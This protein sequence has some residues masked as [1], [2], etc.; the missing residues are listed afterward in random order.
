MWETVSTC[1]IS[2]ELYINVLPRFL[3]LIPFLLAP[4]SINL[5]NVVIIALLQYRWQCPRKIWSKSC[6]LIGYLSGKDLPIFLLLCFIDLDFLS[7]HNNA[8]KELSQFP[9]I[10]TSRIYRRV[11]EGLNGVIAFTITVNP[12]WHKITHW[13][14][15]TF[16]WLFSFYQLFGKL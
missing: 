11:M 4:C 6:V 13:K 5:C 8:K 10:L 9:A 12:K 15:E 7:V 1:Y 16:L 2:R 3:L 14:N